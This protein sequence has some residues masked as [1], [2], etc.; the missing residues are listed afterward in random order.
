MYILKDY[1][2]KADVTEALDDEKFFC[3]YLWL[4]NHSFAD[5]MLLLKNNKCEFIAFTKRMAN[6]FNLNPLILGKTFNSTDDIS[7]G[8]KEEIFKQEQL[9]LKNQIPQNSFYFYRKDNQINN[10]FV[11]KRPL[12]NPATKNAV[13]IMVVTT[14]VQ[15]N[16]QRRFIMKE[17]LGFSEQILSS[18]KPDL[19]T[20]HQQILFCL[21]LGINNRKEIANTLSKITGK[22]IS[23]NQIKNALQALYKEFDC[24]SYSQ[25]VTLTL[26]GQIPFQ[27]PDQTIPPGNY[28]IT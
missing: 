23:E 3:R 6:E 11:R 10:Y 25:L 8:V 9:L 2:E 26:N 24:S 1:L 20:L 13:G 28:L 27:I 16:M 18:S 12:I 15:P 17:F 5:E 19:G 21:L 4:I 22:E 7:E 14:K